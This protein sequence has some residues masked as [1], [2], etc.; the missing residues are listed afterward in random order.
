MRLTKAEPSGYCPSSGPRPE[1]LKILTCN[2]R[3]SRQDDGANAWMYRR[4]ICVAVFMSREPSIVCFQELSFTKFQDIKGHLRDYDYHGVMDEAHSD[5]PRNAIFFRK[6][7][8]RPVAAG[9]FWLSEHPHV[10]GSKSWGSTYPRTAN[11]IRL[12]SAMAQ[13]GEFRVI[14]THLDHTSE[15][16]RVN[17]IQVIL[18]DAC[19]FTASYPQVLA[20]DLNSDASGEVMRVLEGGG[21]TDTYAAVHKTKEPGPTHHA[22]TGDNCTSTAG[23][24]DWILVRGPVEV[25][26]SEIIKDT[27]EGRF[28]SDHYFVS[29]TLRF[30]GQ[31]L[32]KGCVP[33][34]QG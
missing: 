12:R 5:N 33:T 18:D 16:I 22:F 20:G 6:D 34:V 21:F 25:V 28:P 3:S 29:A 32:T 30:Y 14:N 2:I 24:I 11:W 9:G 19:A 7:L 26:D 13:T 31:P 15:A 27:R 1:T 4:D 23:K 8:L 17:Q 10:T